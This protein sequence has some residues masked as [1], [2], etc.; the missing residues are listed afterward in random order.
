MSDAAPPGEDN[1][2]SLT[3]AQHVNA[4]C[5]RFEAAWQAGQ[6]PRI[7][8][9]LAEAAEAEQAVLLH[10]LLALE[11]YYRRLQGEDPRPDD[12]RARFPALD[13][14]GLAAAVAPPAAVPATSPAG[15]APVSTP[16]SIADG[17]TLADPEPGA[18]RCF[19]D[20]E[21]LDEIAR[22]GMGVVYR[23]RQQS[24]NRVVALKMILAGQLASRGEVARFRREAETAAHLDHPHIVPIY[25]VGEHDGQ[26]Y[27]SMK[28]VEGGSLA[29]PGVACG[30][31]PAGPDQ[32]ELRRRQAGVARLMATVARAVHYAHQRG[33][34]HRDL[35]PANILLDGAGQPHVTDFGLA[36]RVEGD[37][38][39]TQSG[40]V[41]GTPSYM[42]PE[43][44]GATTAL[45]TAAD[46]YGLGAVL[47]ELLTGRAPFQAATPLETLLEVRTREPV[48]PRAL[49]PRLDRDLETVCLKCLEKE[50]ARR[51]GSAEALADDLE[52]WR[53]G[54]PIAARPA[55]GPER[56][57]RWCR[58]HPILVTVGLSAVVVLLLTV[59]GLTAGILVIDQKRQETEIAN[60]QAI[61]ANQD[62]EK[63][64]GKERR[65]RYFYGI[66]LADREWGLNN[67][68]KVE[69]ILDDCPEEMRQWEW[70]YLK[71]LCHADLFTL[72]GHTARVLGVTFSPDGSRLASGDTDGNVKVWDATTGR[73]VLTVQGG[74]GNVVFSPDGTRLAT[75]YR[76][77]FGG[78]P[79]PTKG[80]VW[81]ST[82]GQQLLALDNLPANVFEVV[83]S[84]DGRRLATLAPDNTV[85]V[86][87]AATGQ[88]LLSL[89]GPPHSVTK[90][91]FSPDGRLLA[92]A[93]K[94]K[95]VNLW[96]ATTGQQVCTLA[97][98]ADAFGLMAISPDHQRFAS[99]DHTGVVKVWDVRTGQVTHT[100]SRSA[101]NLICNVTFSPAGERLA[102]VGVNGKTVNIWDL[103]TRQ[104]ILTLR[105]HGSYVTEVAF[106]PD[107]RR[108]ASA[109]LDGTV[110]VWDAVSNHESLLLRGHRQRVFHVA[111]SPNGCC[112][113]SASGDRT[114]KV[115]DA[116]TGQEV[117]TLQGH[118][119]SLRGVAFS[120]DGQ[121]LAAAGSDNLVLL[122]DVA[123]GRE[124]EPLRGHTQAVRDVAF[125][126][127]GR[128]LA[129]AGG[130]DRTV[131]VW[132]AQTGQ[133]VCTLRGHTDSVSSV[134]FSS[135]GQHLA[136]CSEDRTVKVW[137]VPSGQEVY[138]LG[139]DTTGVASVAFSPNGR[140]LALAFL[141]GKVQVV[142]AATGREAMT[143]RGTGVS[144]SSVAFTSDG[145][146]L[147]SAGGDLEG[148]SEV[149]L[150]DA[151]TGQEALSL[152]AGS[153]VNC[154][155]F[156]PD[157]NRL[158]AAC[159]DGAVRVWD[160]TPLPPQPDKAA[161]AAPP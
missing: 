19:G 76:N 153:H 93:G 7:E 64:V 104:V 156:S 131:K 107:G 95:R 60:K 151:A 143:I 150:W 103:Q 71:R 8:D 42:A 21:L 119:N 132:D 145:M 97:G 133:E 15:E 36:K 88:E 49:N 114:V 118:T 144:G 101:A 50:P 1:S 2:L 17:W 98:D 89:G 69:A 87:E 34:L 68:D 147:A 5:N 41:V 80:K 61:E 23:A 85:K 73:E 81:D 66:A 52:R 9:A 48:R 138:S 40:A 90:V 157:G 130:R 116:Q 20:Y 18:G 154:V 29:Q 111:F 44:A 142:E 57:W 121:R 4:L 12:Y 63:I 106:S 136:S 123:S 3:A 51:Y 110:K 122:W 148:R 96:D 75:A 146:R 139:P 112:L 43:Q 91:V 135:D 39:L 47:Y 161:T 14:A 102:T 149:M 86:R 99:A 125:S 79:P 26:P 159:E 53:A 113:A 128:W 35:K 32:A 94:D 16:R 74:L 141:N 108:L 92:S 70:R 129:S 54:E 62:L 72:R 152:S 58:R 37:G 158:A 109:C 30:F 126:P 120:A 59:V 117:R 67:P 84:P 82:T 22:G 137:D 56:V 100:F 127:D 10:E 155:A 46:V 83:F 31:G 25:E 140:R 65:S 78:R 134:A 105:G 124:C 28:L 115:W 33:V 27:F 160:A 55:R 13:P 45:S 11:V 38:G 6:R 77:L 24:L